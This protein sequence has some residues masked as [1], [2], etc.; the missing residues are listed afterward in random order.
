MNDEE[1]LEIQ[2]NLHLLACYSSLAVYPVCPGPRLLCGPILGHNENFA[3]YS[4]QDGNPLED[5]KQESN[6]TR[7][8]S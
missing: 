6:T 7:L 5:F 8:I 3:F 4:R 1:C 2:M